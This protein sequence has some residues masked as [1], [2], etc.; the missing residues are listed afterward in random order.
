[1]TSYPVSA[2][3]K[4][5]KFNLRFLPSLREKP[6]C[7]TVLKPPSRVHN[8]SK[9]GQCLGVIDVGLALLSS[10]LRFSSEL[11]H[12]YRKRIIYEILLNQLFC[13]ISKL[14]F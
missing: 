12:L 8:V 1:M 13:D 9:E 14:Q 10:S 5:G 2:A 3:E 4:M 6:D 11:A 7:G